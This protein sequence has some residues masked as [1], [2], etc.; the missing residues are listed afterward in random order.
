M[1]VVT[2]GAAQWRGTGAPAVGLRER[3]TAR[4][5]GRRGSARLDWSQ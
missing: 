3:V 2:G 1:I 4:L 5:A